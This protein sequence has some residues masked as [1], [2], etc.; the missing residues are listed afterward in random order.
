LGFVASNYPLFTV[1]DLPQLAFFLWSVNKLERVSAE[2]PFELENVFRLLDAS[3]WGETFF[4]LFS[5]IVLD[6]KAR[7]VEDVRWL[8]PA[9]RGNLVIGS[10]YLVL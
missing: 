8:E 6:I 2:I 10:W 3:I 1:S 9:L 4:M 5:Q 7:V